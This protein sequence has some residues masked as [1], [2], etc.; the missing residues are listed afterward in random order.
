MAR[1]RPV[2]LGPFNRAMARHAGTTIAELERWATAVVRLAHV[3]VGV[4]ALTAVLDLAAEADPGALPALAEAASAAA[5]IARGAG[6][7]SLRA[8]LDTRLA[9]GRRPAGL[10]PDAA[11]AFWRSFVR[12]AARAPDCVPALAASS[13]TIL[14]R[15]GPAGLEDMVLA[16]LRLG[17]ASRHSFFELATDDARRLLDRLSGDPHFDGRQKDLR[18][19]SAALWGH[20]YPL[21][22]LPTRSDPQRPRR[23][24][25]SSGIVLLPSSV[26]G[27]RVPVGADLFRAAVAHATAHLALGGP[28]FPLGDLKPMQ[29]TLVGLVEDA[30]IEAIAMRRFPGLRALWSPF[31]DAEASHL[32]TAPV[33][34]ARLARALFDPA[35]EDR[36]GLVEKGRRLFAAEPDLHDPGLSRRIGNLLG[37][38]FGQMRIQ[39]D[40]RA[41]VIEPAYRD[42]NLGLWHLP[43]PPPD[44]PM[45]TVDL[46]IE[47]VRRDRRDTLDGRRDQ[48]EQTGEEVSGRARPVAPDTD[49]AIV[50]ALLPEWDRVA[51]RERPA[52]VTLRDGAL[53]PGRPEVLEEALAREPG[54]RHRMRRLVRGAQAGRPTRLRRQPD[55][56][57][58]DMDAVL[59][60]AVALRTGDVPDERIHL[61]KGLR[62][63]DLAVT[64]LVD[65]SESTRDRVP[66]L[67]CAVLDVEQLAVATLADAM[68][69][70][71]DR[72]A[73]H[74]F[75][76]NGR[77]DVRLLRIKSFAEPYGPTV[78]ARLAGLSPGL[79]TRL[80]AALR[81]SGAELAAV[82]ATR[83]ILLVV[84]D[85]APSDIDVP[86]VGDL[87]EDARQAVLGLHR[88]GIDAFGLTLDGVGGGAGAAVFGR[89]GH[90]PVR[91]IEDLPQRLSDLYFRISRR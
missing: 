2:L 80:G 66:G 29:L 18:A 24:A 26:R 90:L 58:L 3:N 39:F 49:Q 57:D 54:L 70:L 78:K 85:G 59:D 87:V 72:F 1:Q 12:L 65:L 23:T 47:A 11:A 14:D 51:R 25:V 35:F 27:S 50:L 34:L 73:I 31:H 36:D 77:E 42:D 81:Y 61:R 84:T 60:A 71:G 76:S 28:P 91:R 74:G 46:D 48:T 79:S 20:A 44:Q 41:H 21:R 83:R 13:P 38:D 68:A 82:A 88:H 52:W 64:V 8:V 43:P 62:T 86:E 6:A 55:G 19:F 32:K 53:Q 9:L 16:G 15:C 69:A 89:T 37:N 33:L 4:L 17:A 10:R 75:C 40:A 22:E 63:R 7:A 45:P 67:D 30:R 5:D 56:V